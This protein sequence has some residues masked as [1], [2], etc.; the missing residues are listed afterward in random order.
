MALRPHPFPHRSRSRRLAAALWLVLLSLAARAG[1]QSPPAGWSVAPPPGWV[2]DCPL[3]GAA[4]PAAPADS[5][6]LYLLVDHQVRVGRTTT[7][8]QRFA[9]TPLSTAGV[10]NASEI[11]IPFDPSYERLSIHHVRLLRGGK[12]VF[13][14]RPGDVRVIQ[15]EAGLD[16]QIYSGELTAV[17]FIRDLRPGDTVDYAYSVEGANPILRGGFDA[18]LPL[19]YESPVRLIRH[20]LQAPL[21]WTLRVTPRGTSVTPRIEA[22]GEWRTYTWEARDVAASSADEDEPGWFDPDPQV[23]VSTFASWGDVAEW[24][25]QLFDA[26]LVHS[27]AV[28]DIARQFSNL[29]GGPPESAEAAA[30]FVQDQVRYLGIELGPNSHQPHT[31]EQVLRQRF[32]DCKDKSLLLVAILRELGVDAAPALVDTERRRGLD[33]APPSPFAFDHAIV[34]AVVGGRAVWIDPTESDVGGR[35][36]EREAPEF[37][38]ALVLRP[39]TTGLTAIPLPDLRHPSIELTETYTVGPAGAPSRLDVTTKYRGRAADA[40]R[41]KLASTSGED[42][43]KSYLDDYARDDRDIKP[44]AP[45]QTRDDRT[46]NE[47]AVTE[48]Y[49]LP[50]FWKSGRRELDGWE[51]RNHLPRTVPSSR[52]SPLEVPHPVHVLHRVV[53]RA[54]EEFHLGPYG[55]TISGDAFTFSSRLDASGKE[56]SLSFDYR[57]RADSV[58]PEQFATHGKDMD[59]VRDALSFVITTDLDSPDAPETAWPAWPVA[60]GGG[61]L[62]AACTALAIGLRRRGK[63]RT[64]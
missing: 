6:R 19:A 23:E 64:P 56:M 53:V 15:Q 32:G 20:V 52:T 62:A 5:G 34:Q 49:E 13:S 54:R 39:G 11:Q 30:R 41:R 14:F 29:P 45:P 57:S 31:P 8:Y 10:Q 1:A 40:M 18:E 37:E 27:P 63:E 2:R 16:E 42:L 17:I 7:D 21:G 38:R 33:D 9:W 50:T 36:T 12:D 61:T 35:L 4:P 22:S 28:S 44:L 60:L 58:R 26:Q 59:R 24:A 25:T 47:L 46:L 3:P 51:I 48:S 55:E 43:A